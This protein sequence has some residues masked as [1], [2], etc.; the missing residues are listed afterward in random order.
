MRRS[1]LPQTRLLDISNCSSSALSPSSLFI[2]LCIRFTIKQFHFNICRYQLAPVSSNNF[3]ILH[4]NNYFSYL[5]KHRLISYR[6]P[7]RPNSAF[8]PRSKFQSFQE[9]LS[10]STQCSVSAPGIDTPDNSFLK[11]RSVASNRLFIL[12]AIVSCSSFYLLCTL[13]IIWYCIAQVVKLF[14]K[15]TRWCDK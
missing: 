15:G 4:Y 5:C 3:P 6:V 13:V 12:F 14:Q 1:S 8:F 11:K 10:A 7:P 2:Y 9:T